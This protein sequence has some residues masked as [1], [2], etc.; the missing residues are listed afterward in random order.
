MRSSSL[1]GL[2]R[3]R[4]VCVALAF[5]ALLAAGCKKD[6]CSTQCQCKT[7]GN[8]ARDG[9]R[10]VPKKDEHCAASQKCKIFGAC[11][12]VDGVCTPRNEADCAQSNACKLGQLCAFS[13][14]RCVKK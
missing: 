10:C 14:G 2:T 3:S 1:L 4:L 8:C 11:G 9:N 6:P 7:L 5:G 12:A 13:G